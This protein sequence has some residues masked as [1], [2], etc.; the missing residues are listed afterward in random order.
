VKSLESSINDQGGHAA[1]IN[2]TITDLLGSIVPGNSYVRALFAVRKCLRESG[3]RIGER[4]I[5]I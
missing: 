2:R 3:D 1:V 5:L 4:Y